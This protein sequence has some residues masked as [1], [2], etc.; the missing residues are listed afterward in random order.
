MLESPLIKKLKVISD[1]GK[2][3]KKTH[4]VIVN[5][6]KEELQYYI[7]NFVYNHPRYRRL[8]MYGGT[9]LRIGYELP[10]MSEDLDFQT[11][12]RIDTEEFKKEIIGHFY[13][14]YN[15]QLTVTGNIRPLSDALMLKINFD[16][17][18]NFDL[19]DIAWVT[20]RIRLDINFFAK[21]DNF[22]KENLPIGLQL[23]GR[24]LGEETLLRIAYCYE[25]Q[26]EW[27]TR[28]PSL[29]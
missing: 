24:P 10:R 7:L 18:K 22:T 19:S 20:L 21:T 28:R 12:E 11:G 4:D 17:L 1:D 8:V 5:K 2:K 26:T 9:L 15:I 16:I 29:A 27:H 23:I 6:L 25:Q 14:T 3:D 13:K